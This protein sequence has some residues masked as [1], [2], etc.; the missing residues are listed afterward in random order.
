MTTASKIPV[1]LRISV[2]RIIKKV[3]FVWEVFCMKIKICGLTR[4]EDVLICNQLG[5]DALGFILAESPR[6]VEIEDVKL[7]TKDLSPFISKV[8]VTMNPGRQLL[9]DILASKLFNYIQFHGSEDPQIIKNFPLRT[10]KSISIG[11]ETQINKIQDEMNRYKCAD[12]Y[13]FDSKVGKNKGG[14]GKSFDWEVFNLL[15]IK[16]PFILAG[17]LGIDNIST[18][19]MKVNMVAVDLNSKLESSP[20]IKDKDLLK[21]IVEIINEH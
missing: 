19:L 20:G 9:E 10:I 14:T 15:D 1:Y 6:Q 11:I 5:V 12:Y 4:R 18:A 8:A 13:L 21:K 7:L 17:G 16:K 2:M 3:C